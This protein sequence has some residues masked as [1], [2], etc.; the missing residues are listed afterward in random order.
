MKESESI[1]E[2]SNRLLDIANR[3]RL[4]GSAFNDSRIVQKILVT[5]PE[6]FE[7]SISALESTKDLTQISLAEILNA[8][9]AQEQRRAKRQESV[10]ERALLAKHQDNV[11]NNKKKFSKR[12]QNPTGELGNNKAGVKK[13][14][15]PPCRHCNRKGHPPF[16]CWRRPDA[17]CTKCNQMGH[18][19]VICKARINNKV[20]RLRLLIRRRKINCLWL[21]ASWAINQ[22]K[23]S[24]LT[25]V[26]PTI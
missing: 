13:G 3:I 15:Y 4:L 19:A 18:E 20:K 16:K 9:Q 7:A 14:S 5:V 2:Y 25:V 6:K 22:M 8:L 24:S 10:V 23:A 11:R 26:A 17:K 21:H 12:N 1:K